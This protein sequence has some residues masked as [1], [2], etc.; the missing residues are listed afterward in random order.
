MIDGYH[1]SRGVASPTPL[2]YFARLR[3]LLSNP[4][5]AWPED[6]F[7]QRFWSQP[8]PGLHGRRYLYVLDPDAIGDVLLGKAQDFSKGT[9]TR[10][11]LG[12]LVG[13]ALLTAE[14][15]HWKWQRHAVASAFRYDRLLSV[16]PIAS[17]AA[18]KVVSRWRLAASDTVHDVSKDMIGATFDVILNGLLSGGEGIDVERTSRELATY[19]ETI[20]RP[21]LLDLFGLP[22]WTRVLLQPRGARARNYLRRAMGEVVTARRTH[23]GP[24]NDLLSMLFDARDPETGQPM[25]GDIL[26]DNLLTFVAAGHETTATALTWAL[27]L[28]SGH[29]PV[30]AKLLEEVRRVAAHGPIVAEHIKHLVFTRQVL[31]ESMRLYPPAPALPRTALRD[32]TIAGM[33]VGAGTIILIPIYALHRHRSLWTAPD[34]F[35]PGR[36]SPARSQG[37]HRFVYL[38]FGGGQRICIG[39]GFALIEAVAM[40]ATFVRAAEFSHDSSHRIRPIMGITLRPEGGMPMRISRREAPGH[41]QRPDHDG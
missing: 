24:T 40:L 14:G 18:E 26:R 16:A 11:L 15:A 22:S 5:E 23:L 31:L 29:P 2:A 38:P 33:S 7:E 8:G 17:Q 10:R 36:F 28:V 3:R 37:R 4:L 19:L 21:T 41:W 39:M 35:D 32:T 34:T 20:G 27:Y 1:T 30:E 13:D 9:I 25:S 12:P 6:V